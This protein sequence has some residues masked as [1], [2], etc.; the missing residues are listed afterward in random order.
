MPLIKEALWKINQPILP[1]EQPCQ[2]GGR[3]RVPVRLALTGIL[4]VARTGTAWE[5]LPLEP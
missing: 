3:L 1:P 4:F 5:L 2:K